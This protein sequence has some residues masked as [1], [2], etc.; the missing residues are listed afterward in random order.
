MNQKFF[1]LFNPAGTSAAKS[2][3]RINELKKLYH[4]ANVK[5]IETSPDGDE[6]NRKIIEQTAKSFDK[7]S[8]LGIASGDGV[9]GMVIDTLA[10][11]PNLSQIAQKVPILPLWGGNANDLAVMLN[12]QSPRSLKPIINRAQVVKIYPLECKLELQDGSQL[13]RTSACYISFGATARAASRM[14]RSKHRDNPLHKIPGMILVSEFF[15]VL[16]SLKNAPLFRIKENGKD[17]K[18]Y[19]KL[20]TN[21]PNFAKQRIFPLKLTEKAYHVETIRHKRYVEATLQVARSIY[22]RNKHS[23]FAT[24]ATRFTCLEE[25]IAQFDGEPVTIQ[26]NTDITIKLSQRPFYALSTKLKTNS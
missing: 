17:I 10:T 1:V 25:T 22:L 21:G 12:G 3:K 4:K 18:I 23:N 7:N 6:A 16:K 15:S 26:P 11:S 24:H 5:V 19:E 2:K 8:V 20:F 14:Q 13:T 9:V